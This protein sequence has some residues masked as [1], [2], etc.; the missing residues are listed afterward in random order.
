M[1]NTYP[2]LSYEEAQKKIQQAIAKI[3]EGKGIAVD[4][5]FAELL[6]KLK[7]I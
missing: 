4:V 5:F 2:T 3:S 6:G 1:K 7:K